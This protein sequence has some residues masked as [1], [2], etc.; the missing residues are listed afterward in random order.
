MIQSGKARKQRLFRYT[1]PMHAKQ[2]FAHAHIDKALRTKLNI[3]KRAIQISKGDTVKVM[4]GGKR[5]TTGKVTRVNLRTGRLYLDSLMKKN[6]RGKEFGVSISV[7]N[8][9]ITDLNLSD[10]VRAAKLKVAVVPQQKPAAPKA[11]KA[12]KIE[13]KKQVVEATAQVKE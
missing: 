13:E 3:K 4:A 9:Y 2:H 10:K 8:V 12:E 1:A 6:A 5:G 11:E 7:N